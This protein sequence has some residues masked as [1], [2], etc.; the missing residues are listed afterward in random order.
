MNEET[1]RLKFIS[2]IDTDDTHGWYVRV[3]RYGFSFRKLFSDK[4]LGNKDWAL[5]Q[6]MIFTDECLEKIMIER[7]Q[8]DPVT[9]KRIT[10]YSRGYAYDVFEVAWPFRKQIKKKSFSI[11]KFGE[12]VAQEKAEKWA[13]NVRKQFCF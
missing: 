13:R 6:A 10:K 7:S 1:V 12:T 2:R 5:M 4:K 9:V 3:E 8:Q 11:K